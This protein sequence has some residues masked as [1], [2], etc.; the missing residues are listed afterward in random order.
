[1]EFKFKLQKTPHSHP[2][3]AQKAQKPS[4][5]VFV[6]VSNPKEAKDR[7]TLQKVRRHVMKDIGRSRKS[8]LSYDSTATKSL[9]QVGQMPTY[10][11]DVQ[12]CVNVKRVFWAMEMVSGALL[13]ITIVDPAIRDQQKITR[14]QDQPPSLKDIEQYTQSLGTVRK[15]ILAESF[16]RQRAIMGTVICLAVFDMRVG[17]LGSWTMHMAGLQMILDLTGGVEALDPNSPLRQA[18]FL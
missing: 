12:V 4:S 6:N 8:P 10:W 11:G 3:R 14:R 7:A 1:M 16:V 9:Y 13:S 5:L 15:S 2:A 18:L 17:N